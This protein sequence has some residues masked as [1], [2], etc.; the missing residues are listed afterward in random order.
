MKD[1]KNF[2]NQYFE[3]NY[4]RWNNLGDIYSPN[5]LTKDLTN[6][7]FSNEEEFNSLIYKKVQG[8]KQKQ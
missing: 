7:K 8:K 4:D 5:Y 2:D 6:T 3:P 1:A